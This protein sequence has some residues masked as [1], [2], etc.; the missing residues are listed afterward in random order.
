[1]KNHLLHCLALLIFLFS[2]C[3]KDDN[4]D[5][6]IPQK[7]QIASTTTAD[8]TKVIL[9]S[10]QPKLQVGYNPVYLSMEKASGGY[11]E[12]AV[13]IHSLMDMHSMSHSSPV[14]QPVHNKDSRLHE[15]AVVLTMPS[16]EMGNWTLEVAWDSQT[17]V[18]NIEAISPPN[19]VKTVQT[20]VGKDD[21]RYTV[22]LVQPQH[23][24][25]GLN[26][27]EFLINYRVDATS[28]PPAENLTLSF[29]PE[30]PSMGHGSPNNM[31]PQHIGK[32]HYSGKI[33]FTMT[34][35][36]RIHVKLSKNGAL[37]ADGIYLDLQF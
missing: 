31:Q 1:M 28:F 9:W 5:F 18:L 16:G 37:V 21:I 25:V 8:E 17:A 19:N 26:D 20:V 13:H 22:S 10:D 27:V 32:G 4:S 14:E 12:S 23:P 15:G 33:N 24:K 6:L 7:E 3:S 2:S 35:D 36:W 11:M 34:G 29:E 30:M